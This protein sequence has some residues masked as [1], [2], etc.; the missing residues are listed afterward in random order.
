M[1]SQREYDQNG[2]YEVPDNP[3][4]KA[5]IFEYLGS[6]IGAPDPDKVYMVFRPEEELNNQETIDSFKL[7]P[8]IDDHEML[9]NESEGLT[10]AEKKGVHGVIGE[11]VKYSDGYL[12][13]NLKVFS[14]EQSEIIDLGKKDLSLGFRCRYDFTPGTFNGERYDVIQRQIRGN[15]VAS[16]DEGRMGSEVSVM[17]HRETFSFDSKDIVKMN[18]KK[19]IV[20]AISAAVGTALD[21]V[22]FSKLGMDAGKDMEKDK[23]T[24]KD[25]DKEKDGMDEEKD[26]K[27]MDMEKDKEKGMDADKDKDKK[28]MDEEEEDECM[29]KDK[30]GDKMNSKG[31]DAA[32]ARAMKPLLAKINV[33]EGKQSSAMDTKDVI[34]QINK[35]DALAGRLSNFVGTFDHADMTLSEVEKYGAE[36]LGLDCKDGMEG[37]MIEGFLHGRKPEQSFAVINGMDSKDKGV[38]PLNSYINGDK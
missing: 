24:G 23:D 30:K 21:S 20:D 17:D 25:K 4:S 31:M 8:L 37:A 27:G 10:P 1:A 35:R 14:E 6:S 34:Q 28:G 29:D 22:D 18:Q 36:K 33:L 3:I 13:G 5:G 38:N 7:V 12:R 26:D 2:W 19:I 32:I 9:G 11:K 15:H 16:V